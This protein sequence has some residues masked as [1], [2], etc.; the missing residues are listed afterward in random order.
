[1]SERS[2]AKVFSSMSTP[3][4]YGYGWGMIILAMILFAVGTIYAG[5][6][7]EVSMV[8]PAA[9][10]VQVKNENADAVNGFASALFFVCG[11]LLTVGGAM[12]LR[13][14]YRK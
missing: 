1:M 6:A 11:A 8:M 4:K 7:A 13:G 12:T 9:S 3:K 14:A 5:K 2:Q 10:A